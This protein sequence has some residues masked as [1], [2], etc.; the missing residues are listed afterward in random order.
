[1]C[2]FLFPFAWSDNAI[3]MNEDPSSLQS[4][5]L[6]RGDENRQHMQI[7]PGICP[8]MLFLC[9][10][11]ESSLLLRDA[12]SSTVGSL[13][14]LLDGLA[15]LGLGWYLSRLLLLLLGELLHV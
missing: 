5:R 8:H 10:R 7:Q 4:K 2:P 15:I 11:R 13:D 1:M 9:I 12:L 3:N 14:L 6:R